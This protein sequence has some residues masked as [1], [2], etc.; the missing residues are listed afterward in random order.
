MILMLPKMLIASLLILTS[1]TTN[2]T[3]NTSNTT[4]NT[5]VPTKPLNKLRANFSFVSKTE[6]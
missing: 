6:V 1:S 5:A 4:N 2:D 3:N